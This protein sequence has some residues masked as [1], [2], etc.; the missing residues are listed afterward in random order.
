MEWEWVRAAPPRLYISSSRR[1]ELLLLLMPDPEGSKS[2]AECGL[3]RA[4][5]GM[6]G[7][8]CVCAACF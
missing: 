2:V 5:R 8:V 4:C 6:R 7:R 3:E 1:E